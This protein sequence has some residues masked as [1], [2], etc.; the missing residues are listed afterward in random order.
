MKILYTRSMLLLLLLCCAGMSPVFAQSGS[1]SGLVSDEINKPL[2]GAVIRVEG[3]KQVIQ[4][5]HQGRYSLTGLKAGPITLSASFVGYNQV[6]MSVN[7]DTKQQVLNFQLLPVDQKL[8]EV[9]IIGYGTQKKQ[10]LTGSITTVSSKDFQKGVITSPEQLIQGKVA[11]VSVVSNGGQPGAGSMIRIRGGASLNAS[12][13]PLIVIDGIPLSGN[14]INNAPNQ[15]ALINPVDIESFTVLKDANA[16]A[17]YGSRAS[18]GVILITTKKGSKGAT[19]VSFSTNNAYSTIAKKVNVLSPEEIRAYVGAH[20]NSFYGT[21]PFKDLLGQSNTDWQNEIYDN[22]FSTDN[23]LS[24]SG[25][26]E[27]MPY[28][29]SAGYLDQRGMLITDRFKR[30]TG[31]IGIFPKLFNEHLKI[32][33]NLK[34]SLTDAHFANQGAIIGAMQFDPTQPVYAENQFG[35]Y[36][37]WTGGGDLN[38][39]APRNP[40]SQIILQ[41]NNGKTERSFGNLRLDYSF[42]FL[43]ELHANLNLGYDVSRGYGSI[44]VPAEAGQNFANGG[45]NTQS[46]STQQNKVGEFYLSYLKELESLNSK[47]DLTA[48]Y[49]FYDNISKIY[50][51]KNFNAKG[52]VLQ[53]PSFPFDIPRQKLMSYYGRLVYTY[54]DR[55]I[56]SG[57]MRT[58]GS[59]RFARENRWGYFP[60]VGFTWRVKGENFLKDREAISDLKLRLSYGQTGNQDGIAN[61]NYLAKYYLNT[62]QGQYQMGNRFYDYFSPSEYDPDMR[63]ESTTTYNAGLDYGLFGGRVN[64]TLDMYYKE[65]KNLLSRVDIPSGTNF[66]NTLLTNIGNMEVRGAEL[67]FNVAVVKSQNLNWD[68][69]FNAAYNKRKVTN[70]SLNPD[71]KFKISAG[72]ISGGTGINIKYNGIGYTPQSFFVYKQIYDPNGKPLEGIYADLNKD[73]I[74]N[75]DDQYF[76]RSPDPKFVLGFS[77]SFNL[78]RWTLSSVLRSNIGNYVYD[79]VSSNLGVQASILNSR[80]FINNANHDVFNTGFISNQYLSDY[81][82]KDASFVK[83]DNLNLAFDAGKLFKGSNTA[84]K[85]SASCQNVFVITKYKGLDPEVF[86]GIDYNLYP[87]PRIYSLALNVGF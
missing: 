25:T 69:G 31:G 20:P 72:G 21:T 80:G 49:G 19:V 83:M 6:K 36:F 58:D 28:R 57:T 1:V 74:I 48:G 42:H 51:F 11:G 77:T 87:R 47:V 4:S 46:N 2:P 33:L 3:T 86:S 64:G 7:I 12:N 71:P 67:N 22:A 60:S 44:H 75:T 84:V 53:T 45:F 8:N 73:G 29:V 5:D 56:L 32:D 78:R 40:V 76:Y 43:P 66:N 52:E 55:Y 39:N 15:L 79:N 30:A 65:T 23:N 85:I 26:F 41:D 14:V 59:S 27:G 68:L 70:L 24:L 62:P 81:Y 18:N 17:I 37:E 82:I 35:N 61:Y 63:W 54:A 38:R 10:D 16:T 9:V 34:G 13:D 50:N